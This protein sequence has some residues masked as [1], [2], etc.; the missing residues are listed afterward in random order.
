MKSTA[1]RIEK[2]IKSKPK[3]TI[4]FPSDFIDLGTSEAIRLHLFR[5]EKDGLIKRIAQG[6]YVRPRESKLLGTLSPS[7]EE[8][9]SSI[10]KRDRIRCIPTGSYALHALGLSNQVP[11]KIVLLTDGSARVI[12]I[13]NRSITFKKTTP[14][15][16]M[17]R[18]EISS[19]V[20]QA[21]KEIGKGKISHEEEQRI[22]ELLKQESHQNLAHDIKLAPVW[23]QKI[24]QKAQTHDED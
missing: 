18:G 1:E 8:V 3:G 22:I 14:K 10:A 9:A 13:G 24:M 5:L 20:I 23:I 7:A 2:R 19:L 4:M 21:V 11:M 6:I 15:N 17:T 16:L 12:N